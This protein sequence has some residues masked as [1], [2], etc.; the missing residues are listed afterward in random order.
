MSQF[1]SL[2]AAV[3]ANIRDGDT[4]FVGSQSLRAMELDADDNGV[5]GRLRLCEG[6]LDR[7]Y[8]GRGRDL[9]L[10]AVRYRMAERSAPNAEEQ[11]H[12]RVGGG[13]PAG[14]RAS[15]NSAI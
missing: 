2:A 4:V 1:M 3:E 9:L 14:C 11:D 6:H 7:I 5:K 12:Q 13:R 10:R 8:G 15:S